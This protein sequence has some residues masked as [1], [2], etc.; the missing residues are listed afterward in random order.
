MGQVLY[1]CVGR[2]LIPPFLLLTVQMQTISLLA[3]AEK[4]CLVMSI[5]TFNKTVSSERAVK[6]TW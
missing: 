6:M 5:L 2:E 4:R 3:F 1:L